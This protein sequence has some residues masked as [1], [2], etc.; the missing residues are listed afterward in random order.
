MFKSYKTEINPTPDQIKVIEN[1]FKICTVAYNRYVS[2]NLDRIKAGRKL[3]MP[4]TYL[5][6]IQ[7]GEIK[8]LG[9]EFFIKRAYNSAVKKTLENGLKVLTAYANGKRGEPKLKAMG[10]KNIS[11]YFYASSIDKQYIDCQRHRINIPFLG[12]IRIKEKGYIPTEYN[13]YIISGWI[14]KCAG[15]YYV[16]ALVKEAFKPVV[17]KEY[18]PGIGIDLNVSNFATLSDG[19]VFD[20]INK[21]KNMVQLRKRLH[22]EKR[23]L[24]RKYRGWKTYSNML[25]ATLAGKVTNVPVVETTNAMAKNNY[26]KNIK[27]VDAIYNRMNCIRNDYVRKCIN[28][29]VDKNPT[30]VAVEDLKITD[31]VS[32]NRFAKYVA[33][34][35]FYQFKLGLYKK[36]KER[37]IEFRVVN[38]WYPSTRRCH[39]C[40]YVG[41][42]LNVQYRNFV[43]P[44]CGSV[45]P[46]DLNASLNIRDS[47]DYTV[48]NS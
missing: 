46:R 4:S 24:G 42:K 2:Y 41:S 28:Q 12:W 39:D 43:C 37:G 8:E 47:K 25:E 10:T 14:K 11:L 27:R 17:V 13:K 30:F 45:M 1:Y 40:G 5:K 15:R 26:F 18:G 38:H 19:T 33:D 7:T 36:C 20:N 48:W 9:S 16:S 3:I 21:S 31:M 6:M 22:R 44:Q 23:S 34:E 35:H 29:I 32:D